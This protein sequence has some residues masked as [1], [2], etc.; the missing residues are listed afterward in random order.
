MKGNPHMLAAAWTREKTHGQMWACSRSLSTT[1][2]LCDPGQVYEPLR[3]PGL[4]CPSQ[5]LY[6]EEKAHSLFILLEW[7]RFFKTVMIQEKNCTQYF[8]YLNK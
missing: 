2:S 5:Y 1:D 3:G 4:P 8:T 7:C 6:I